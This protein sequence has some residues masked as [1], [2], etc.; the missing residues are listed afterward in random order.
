MIKNER[1]R[2]SPSPDSPAL[3]SHFPIAAPAV[4][5]KLPNLRNARLSHA[6]RQAPAISAKKF[7][8]R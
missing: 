2:L 5:I 7:A 6:A 1:G 8:F 3:S 4:M